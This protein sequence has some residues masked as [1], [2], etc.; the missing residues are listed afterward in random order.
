MKNLMELVNS[1]TEKLQG[2]K[3]KKEKTAKNLSLEIIFLSF[4]PKKKRREEK[5]KDVLACGPMIDFSA[6]PPL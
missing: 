2:Q 1:P 3:R 5:K 4:G 6:P